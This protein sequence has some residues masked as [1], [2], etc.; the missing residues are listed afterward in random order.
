MFFPTAERG[1]RLPAEA[2]S[3]LGDDTMKRYGKLL[4][5]LLALAGLACPA[6]AA[7]LEGV[8][9]PDKATVAGT[10]LV[11]NGMGLRTATIFKVK[12]YVAGLYVKEKA[13]EEKAILG[14]AGPKQLRM[15]FLREVDAEKIASAWDDSLE[16][17]REKFKAEIE[18]LKAMMTKAKDG[19]RYTYTFL[20]DSVEVSFND[21]SKGK[22]PGGEF[23]R[24]LLS[25]WIGENP[26][27]E[28]LKK[29]LLGQTE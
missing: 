13:K 14:A 2:I 12:V 11:L 9:M 16:K 18:K 4:G 23:G 10:E 6:T 15:H 22:L 21:Q 28:K 5:V 27:T 19:D 1:V 24:A 29:G 8:K 20:P 25:T 3:I 26:P 17:S 7:E